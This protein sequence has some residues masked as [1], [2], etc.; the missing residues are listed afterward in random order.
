[1]DNCVK[2]IK[3]C[4]FSCALCIAACVDGC[5]NCIKV[6]QMAC[7]D[8]IK[9]HNDLLKNVEFMEKKVKEGLGLETGNEP[10]HS[11]ETIRPWYAQIIFHPYHTIHHYIN[12]GVRGA[13]PY[14]KIL[15][16]PSFWGFLGE[17]IRF[18]GQFFDWT[19]RSSSSEN[20]KKDFVKFAFLRKIFFL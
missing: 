6:I 12:P 4:L 20:W 7:G 8:G 19:A 17:K 18:Y 15:S 5:Y 10:L 2:G 9:S 16:K 13:T 11:L 14:G 1:M 3:Y